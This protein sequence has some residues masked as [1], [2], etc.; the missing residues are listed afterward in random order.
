MAN[1]RSRGRRGELEAARVLGGE[2]ISRTGEEGSDITDAWGFTW[3]VKRIKA[4]TRRIRD[5]YEQADR[6]GD[7]GVIVRED[8]GRWYVII[9]ADKYMEE[10]RGRIDGR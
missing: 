7:F 9:E 6:Q 3:E 8:R 5:W 2:R 10:K 4:W 1:N